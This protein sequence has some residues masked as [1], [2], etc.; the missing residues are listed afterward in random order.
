MSRVSP[1]QNGDYLGATATAPTT[2][3]VPTHAMS[4]HA[5]VLLVCC[6]RAA[7]SVPAASTNVRTASCQERALLSAPERIGAVTKDAAR[8]F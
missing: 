4:R 2:T 1:H 7:S 8:F 3:L 5:G 6:R